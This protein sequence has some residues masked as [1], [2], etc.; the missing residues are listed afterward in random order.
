MITNKVNKFI[1]Y[2]IILMSKGKRS[3][4]K[5]GKGIYEQTYQYFLMK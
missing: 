2:I 3:F 5:T 1:L 4:T